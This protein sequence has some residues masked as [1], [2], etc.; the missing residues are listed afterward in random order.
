MDNQ[1]GKIIMYGTMWC[2]DC[3]RARSLFDRNDIPYQ[4][5]D[6]SRDPA[7]LEYVMKVNNGMRSVPTILFPDEY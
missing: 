2:G 3:F 5:V 6:I 1:N 4:W 7:G